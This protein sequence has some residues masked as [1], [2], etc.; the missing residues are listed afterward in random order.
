MTGIQRQPN[1]DILLNI[2]ATVG[3]M[4][5]VEYKNDLGAATWTPLGP[6][7][8]ATSSNLPITDTIGTNTQRF[9]RVVQL[10]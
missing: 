8:V 5:R 6:D 4:Y 9:Y 10:N 1:G 2:G 3:K 7:Q